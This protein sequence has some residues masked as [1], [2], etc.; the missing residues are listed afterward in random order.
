MLASAGFEVRFQ[1]AAAQAEDVVRPSPVAGRHCT[2]FVS[3]GR[4][5]G[6]ETNVDMLPS[7]TPYGDTWHFERSRPLLNPHLSEAYA[8]YRFM[9]PR[10][11]K[12]HLTMTAHCTT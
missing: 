9:A 4:G 12:N 2:R 3:P 10:L 8:R 1:Q 7:L 6:V 5:G 11:T